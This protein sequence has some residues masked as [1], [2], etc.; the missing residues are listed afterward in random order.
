MSTPVSEPEPSRWIGIRRFPDWRRLRQWV[1]RQAS[2][3]GPERAVHRLRILVPSAGAAWVLDRTLRE[4]LPP[5][6]SFP[7]IRV[8]S[9]AFDDLPGYL[10][11]PLLPAPPLVREILMEEALVAAVSAEDGFELPDSGDPAQIADLFL[12]FLDEMAADSRVSPAPRRSNVSRSARR[13]VSSKR[14]KP[15]PARCGCSP[16]SAG[17]A[18]PTRT[19]GKPSKTPRARIRGSFASG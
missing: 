18:A 10:E 15:T 1:A 19:T 6:G 8:A 9:S 16:W 4:L 17:S 14:A 12:A 5:G 11:P 3:T 13:G 2:L 7:E